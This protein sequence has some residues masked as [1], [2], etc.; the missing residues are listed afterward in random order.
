MMEII[1]QQQQKE[2]TQ[3]RDTVINRTLMVLVSC[4]TL[5]WRNWRRIFFNGLAC[6]WMNW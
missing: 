1:V 5:R 3:Q 6:Q 2:L 4:L